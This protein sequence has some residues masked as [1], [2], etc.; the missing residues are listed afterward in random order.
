MPP[1][2]LT[3]AADRRAA[4]TNRTVRTSR[5]RHGRRQGHFI[6][7]KHQLVG[8][9]QPIVMA[10]CPQCGTAAQVTSGRAYIDDKGCELAT[11]C[12]PLSCRHFGPALSA[13]RE[14][15]LKL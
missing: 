10:T 8:G 3:T 2:A 12:E 5:F 9:G 14:L 13:A 11:A 7:T 15:L 4:I 6:M 1:I